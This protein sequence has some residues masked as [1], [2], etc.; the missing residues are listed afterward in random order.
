MGPF[1]ESYLAVD[2]FFALSGFVLAHAYGERLLAG[3]PPAQFMAVRLIRLYPLY[4]VALALSLVAALW[5]VAHGRAG[6]IG[7]AEDLAFALVFL[8]SPLSSFFLFPLNGP[9]WSLFCELVANAVYGLAARW[10]RTPVLALVVA[11]AGA[12]LAAAVHTSSLGF[13]SAGIGA[14]SDGFQ[15]G[16]LGAGLSRAAYSF[17]AGVLVYRLWLWWRPSIRIPP[18]L[19]ILALGA[20]LV[21]DPPG[22]YQMAFDLTATLLLFPLLI[23][24]GANSAPH[25][26]LARACTL[27]GVA[28]YAVY[29]LQVPLYELTIRAAATVT[30]AELGTL[31]WIWGAAFM[32]FVFIVALAA[33][34]SVDKPLRAMLTARI[35]G[36]AGAPR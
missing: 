19:L 23:V 26:I 13:G 15:R 7:L 27:M 14:M 17:F 29:V 25:G 4:G 33:D 18:L 34:R 30:G 10:L 21:A 8:P 2:F 32:L 24:L 16:A 12:V 1:F 36:R 35:L 11:L 6:I 3:M 5:D 28:S 20:I 9:A 31:P 22:P